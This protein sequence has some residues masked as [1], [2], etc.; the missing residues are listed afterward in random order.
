MA[1]D[2]D[3]IVWDED[4]LVPA[5][6]Q[7]GRTRAILMMAYMDRAALSETLD[8]GLVH[9]WSRSRQQQW[10]KGETSGNTLTLGAI[11]VDCDSDAL[12]ITARPAGPTCHTGDYSCFGPRET[13]GI[14]ALWDTIAARSRDLPEG[15]YTASLL[16]AGT[17]DVARKV[18]EEA[19]EV[20]IAAKNHQ[21]GGDR[22]RVVEESADLIYHLLVLLA[23]RGVDLEDVERELD[24]RRQ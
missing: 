9:F 20:V 13:S 8:T 3:A 23:E 15:S 12:L 17:D 16:S 11:A 1:L 2:I 22:Q 19:S 4:G 24:D 14:T 10:L 5:I 6:V 18:T 21:F 7:D